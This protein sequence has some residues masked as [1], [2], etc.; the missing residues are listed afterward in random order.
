MTY[1]D[2]I[3]NLVALKQ[4]PAF[5][6]YAKCEVPFKNIID[7]REYHE[8]CVRWDA[9]KQWPNI[10]VLLNTDNKSPEAIVFKKLYKKLSK[11]RSDYLTLTIRE[12][13]PKVPGKSYYEYIPTPT[14]QDVF[15]FYAKCTVPF[16]SMEDLKR[17]H[18]Q[19]VL[20]AEGRE[21]W[22]GLEVLN[23]TEND[24][25]GAKSFRKM[26]KKLSKSIWGDNITINIQ[27]RNPKVPGEALYEYIPTPPMYQD[28]FEFYAKC[29]IP[30]KTY[31]DLLEYHD[32]CVRH[33]ADKRWPCLYLIKKSPNTSP[34]AMAVKDMCKKLG[35]KNWRNLTITI[36]ERV[37]KVPGKSPYECVQS[38]PVTQTATVTP[39]ASVT[40]TVAVTPTAAVTPT[41]PTR[42]VF[43]S[44]RPPVAD[45]K[46][47]YYI[48]PDGYHI[49]K[50]GRHSGTLS[51]LVS[52]YKNGY[53]TFDVIAYEC[54]E[55]DYSKVEKAVLSAMDARGFL[56][57]R[58][59]VKTGVGRF[60]GDTLN[61]MLVKP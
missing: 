55:C 39:T 56:I 53:N 22:P 14:Y 12:I 10:G 11:S 47:V 57:V 30:F 4:Q 41:V 52:R 54:G 20:G 58:E 35:G 8:Q 1:R 37:P 40:P 15:D 31:V 9:D 61:T 46:F 2:I 18:E 45:G 23:S 3:D 28:V 5:D 17:Y 6:F 16:V 32:K 43:S 33:D 19:C 38:A 7:L 24:T 29:D 26:Y 48:Q 44:R 27:E 36:K 42:Y 49:A 34:E 51:Q 25:P 21:N 50:V 59:Q 60:F 13:N